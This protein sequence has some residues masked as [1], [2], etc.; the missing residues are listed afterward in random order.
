MDEHIEKIISKK[1][2]RKCHP[3]KRPKETTT[4]TWIYPSSQWHFDGLSGGDWQVGEGVLPK[5]T[6]IAWSV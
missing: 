4:M 3:R 5:Y 2:L 6:I 1:T